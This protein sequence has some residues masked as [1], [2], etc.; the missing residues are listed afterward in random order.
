MLQLHLQLK[1]IFDLET[2]LQ[3]MHIAELDQNIDR[4]SYLIIISLNIVMKYSWKNY[5]N[6][7]Q[8]FLGAD[9][10]PTQE[11]KRDTDKGCLIT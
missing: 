3:H 4:H 8:H 6:K 1:I 2:I 5:N 7:T 9:S 10:T 11:L